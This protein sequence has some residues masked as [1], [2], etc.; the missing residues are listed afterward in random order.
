MS[1]HNIPKSRDW[2][3]YYAYCTHWSHVTG[4]T[5]PTRGALEEA[6]QDADRHNDEFKGH[7]A[8]VVNI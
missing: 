6:Q 4:W 7:E 8:A 5:G 1:S 2:N 3:S